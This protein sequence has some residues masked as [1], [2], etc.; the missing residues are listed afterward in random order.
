ML[1]SDIF[2]FSPPFYRY[3]VILS[4]KFYKRFRSHYPTFFWDSAEKGRI[5]QVDSV[6]RFFAE[7]PYKDRRNAPD[8]N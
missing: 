1:L 7:P 5:L 3:I 6:L 2:K 8:H 4:H